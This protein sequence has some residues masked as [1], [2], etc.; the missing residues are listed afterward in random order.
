MLPCPYG[1]DLE[2]DA[3][4]K[5]A[6]LEYASEAHAPLADAAP[7]EMAESFAATAGGNP[8]VNLR[9]HNYAI[10]EDVP[11][12]DALSMFVE[13]H[14]ASAFR[15]RSLAPRARASSLRG[16]T[17]R[18]GSAA[19]SC[20]AAPWRPRRVRPPRARAISRGA[21]RGKT[22]ASPAPS[23]ELLPPA[24]ARRRR[25]G[26]VV[27]V[28]RVAGR[29][30]GA[31]AKTVPGSASEP[32]DI[33]LGTSAPRPASRPRPALGRSGVAPD[34]PSDPRRRGPS[35]ET[36]RSGTRVTSSGPTRRRPRS[37]S[38][39]RASGR[40]RGS[41]RGARRRRRPRTRRSRGA[42]RSTSRW[43]STRASNRACTTTRSPPA[44]I[45]RRS[46]PGNRSAARGRLGRSGRGRSTRRRSGTST[47]SSSSGTGST[48]AGAETLRAK[49][50]SAAIRAASSRTRRTP[51][52]IFAG[53]RFRASTPSPA[54]P[55]AAR[56]PSTRSS[57]WSPARSQRASASN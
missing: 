9:R 50:V 29:G 26:R 44:A 12:N 20:V 43:R 27:R 11:G 41:G 19:P 55:S 24:R 22:S 31:V 36:A 48:T 33:A 6:Q 14:S 3:L 38:S 10:V 17:T 23:S 4:Q 42:R 54:R 56:N 39:R 28:L 15:R 8:V 47:A 34:S 46:R 57:P 51:T 1:T 53:T 49:P 18:G 21:A 7:F 30:G 45:T 37:A 16:E 13:N 35:E 32:L 25:R 52:P 2:G 40:G 5:A